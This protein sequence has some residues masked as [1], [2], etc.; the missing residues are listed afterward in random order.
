MAEL[1]DAVRAGRRPSPDGV[2]GRVVMRVVEE[3]YRSAGAVAAR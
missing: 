3:A 2:D 1:V